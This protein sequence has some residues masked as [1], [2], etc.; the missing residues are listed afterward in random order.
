[1]FRKFDGSSEKPTTPEVRPGATVAPPKPAEPPRPAGR[2]NEALS[3]ISSDVT[4]IGNLQSAGDVQIDGKISGDIKSRG[5]IIGESAQVE[6]AIYA[7]TVRIFGTVNGQITAKTVIVAK[8]AR[9]F[10]DIV[11]QAISVEQGA[12]LESHLRRMDSSGGA[13]Q[14]TRPTQ[15]A[16]GTPPS[17][18][19]RVVAG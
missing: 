18:G 14:P 7:D 4:I 5:V 17:Q 1:M 9:I 12:F 2:A 19:T 11:H 8:T 6:G 10:G 15:V 3:I 16:P 13:A